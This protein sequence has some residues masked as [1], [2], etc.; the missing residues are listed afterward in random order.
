MKNKLY[1]KKKII[2]QKNFKNNRLDLILKLFLKSFSRNKIKNFIKNKKVTVNNN[3]C[4]KPSKKIKKKDLINIRIKIPTKNILFKSKI[5]LNKVYED[6]FLL[7]INKEKNKVVHPGAGN[8]KNT[9]LN[10]I[11][12]YYPEM[13]HLYRGGIIHRLDKDTTGLLIIAKNLYIYKLLKKQMKKRKIIRIYKTIVFG[14]IISD[15]LIDKPICRHKYKRKTM[16]VN[17]KKGRKAVT[18]FKVIENFSFCTLLK[19]QLHT[20]RTH[21]I[22]VHMHYIKHPIIGE[23]TYINKNI[24]KNIP[25]IF[26]KQIEILN[27][28][29]LHASTLI[30]KHPYYKKKIIINSPL[31]KDIYNLIFTLRN[32]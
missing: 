10:S 20:G 11:I 4:E 9:L 8:N 15:G 31:P 16:T 26:K 21:Q 23:K 2:I 29:A 24:K 12:F 18:Y 13:Q 5:P 1:I 30:F 32:T 17:K 7:I 6:N 28:Q 27:R 25:K 14:K 22:R 19:V 3:I